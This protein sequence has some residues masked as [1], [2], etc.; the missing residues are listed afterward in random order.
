MKAQMIDRTR[1]PAEALRSSTI[2][3]SRSRTTTASTRRIYGAVLSG[4]EGGNDPIAYWQTGGL[5]D[6]TCTIGAGRAM[7]D[8]FVQNKGCTAQKPPEPAQPP[9]YLSPGGHL[10]TTYSGC[11]SGHALRWCAHQSGHGNAIVDGTSDL[12]N[13]CATPPKSCSSACPCTWVPEDV[14]SFFSSL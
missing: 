3:S 5:T 10:C 14:W 7:R 13:S 4:C 12:Y 9:P 11:S 2:W 6:N 1:A 8:K